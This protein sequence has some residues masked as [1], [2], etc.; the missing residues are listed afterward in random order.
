MIFEL[1]NLVVYLTSGSH[2]E[3]LVLILVMRPFYLEREHL[4]LLSRVS[5]F[6]DAWLRATNFVYLFI[7]RLVQILLI[8]QSDSKHDST[9][10]C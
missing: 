3:Y 8:V 7:F 4:S 1:S 10:R 2:F 9:V 6:H 5:T